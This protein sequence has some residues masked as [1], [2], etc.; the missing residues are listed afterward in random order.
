MYGINVI[1]AQ[2]IRH[3]TFFLERTFCHERSRKTKTSKFSKM[4]DK[5]IES[6][7][8]YFKSVVVNGA[9]NRL[10][11]RSGLGSTKFIFSGLPLVSSFSPFDFA[12]L[13]PVK[14]KNTLNCRAVERDS[15]VSGY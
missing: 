10:K 9:S 11:Y 1:L 4:L 7:F 6:S 2:A 14:I 5:V 12:T 3:E 13:V 8:S 15:A